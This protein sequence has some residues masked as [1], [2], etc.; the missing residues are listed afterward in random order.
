V[1]SIRFAFALFFDCWVWFNFD[2]LE[3]NSP[4]G[5]LDPDVVVDDDD[6]SDVRC[7]CS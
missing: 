5:V 7:C 3:S 4:K 6:L 2:D 1:L